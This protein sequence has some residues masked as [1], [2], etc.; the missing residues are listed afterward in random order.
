MDRKGFDTFVR[1]VAWS[2]WKE[3]NARVFNAQARQPQPLVELIRSEGRLWVAAGFRDL[4][5]FL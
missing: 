4:L 2:L 3:S 5:L 1:L